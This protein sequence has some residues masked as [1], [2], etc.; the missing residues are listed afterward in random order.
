LKNRFLFIL[1]YYLFWLLLLQILRGIFVIYNHALYGAPEIGEILKSFIYGLKLDLSFSSYVAIL[2]FVLICI[3]FFFEKEILIK[4]IIMSYSMAVIVIVAFL[5]VTDFELYKWWGFRLDATILKYI[6]TPKEMIASA[7]VAPVFLLLSLFFFIIS[8]MFVLYVLLLYPL[9]KSFKKNSL[10]KSIAGSLI[11]IVITISLIIPIRG[12]FQLAPMNESA[13]FYSTNP[14]LNNTAVNVPWNFIHSLLEKNYETLN[15]YITGSETR[16]AEIIKMLYESHGKS[17]KILKGKPNIVL[18]IWESFTAKVVKETGGKDRITPQ[19]SKLIK[20]GI[21]F[22]NIYASGDRSDKG[23]IAILSG[24]PSQPTTSIITNP[25]KASHLPAISTDLKN[26]GYSTSFYYGGELEFANIK[27]FLLNHNYDR[28]ISKSDFE[29]KFW[30]SKWGAHDEIVLDRQLEDLNKEKQPFFSTIFTLSSHEP[31][32]IP[33]PPLLPG[34]DWQTKFLNSMYYTDQCIGKFIEKAKKNKWWDNTLFI[35]IADHG[36]LLPGES[37]YPVH[38]PDEF[39]IPMLWLGGAL[40]TQ[41]MVASE[42][43]SQTDLAF[44]LLNQMDMD[45]KKFIFSKDLMNSESTPFAYY[46]FNNGFGYI[47]PGKKIV[48][49]NIS[50]K[51]TYKEGPVTNSDTEEGKAYLQ[52]TFQDYLNK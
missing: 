3:S 15:P 38:I 49:D 9:N 33:I 29:E 26:K 25:S 13:V 46:S 19:F 6:N 8:G 11:L 32:E 7:Y 12:G 36:H 23:L 16:T 44:T 51:P 24:Y 20:E 27:S 35:I 34:Y 1:K 42:I 40:K 43:G 39:H 37:G 18:I 21:L 50:G 28:L 14:L 17:E 30:N 10:P 5:S 31:F 52:F 41:P 48:V 2:P 4:R 22:D 47:K 45:P